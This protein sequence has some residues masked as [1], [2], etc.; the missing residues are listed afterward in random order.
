L[1]AKALF[2]F[3]VCHDVR[4]YT[5]STVIAIGTNLT[6]PWGRRVRDPLP[7]RR[8]N[9][10]RAT[11]LTYE[12]NC[13]ALGRRVPN[14]FSPIKLPHQSFIPWAAV[15]AQGMNFTG[16]L[17]KRLLD[18]LYTDLPQVHSILGMRADD[19]PR[20][21]SL[22]TLYFQVIDLGGFGIR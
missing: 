4:S 16:P 1:R 7:P 5:G 11:L 9:F 22:S 14:L 21:K 10:N 13:E 15:L 3:G 6:C 2:F 8:D 20:N 12:H 18:V 17:E 19:H